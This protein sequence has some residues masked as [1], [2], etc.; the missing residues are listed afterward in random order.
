MSYNNV[1]LQGYKMKERNV[2]KLLHDTLS[3]SVSQLYS[4]QHPLDV[5]NLQNTIYMYIVYE[6][7]E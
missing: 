5:C 3:Y 2:W 1:G 6:S 4:S 7:N